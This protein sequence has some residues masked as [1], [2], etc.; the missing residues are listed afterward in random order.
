MML[1]YLSFKGRIVFAFPKYSES[2]WSVNKDWLEGIAPRLLVS[3][4]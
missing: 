2:S 1:A 3:I 4:G